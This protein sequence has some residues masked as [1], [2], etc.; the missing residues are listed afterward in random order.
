MDAALERLIGL[1]NK[2]Q[3]LQY[4]EN[5]QWISASPKVSYIAKDDRDLFGN[6]SQ[7][8]V[9]GYDCDRD[10]QV[11]EPPKCAILFKKLQQHFAAQ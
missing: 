8:S 5:T 3:F 1:T 11:D 7:I 4:K 6:G 9:S 2:Q 10:G